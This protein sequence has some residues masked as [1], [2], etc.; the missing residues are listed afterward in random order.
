MSYTLLHCPHPSESLYC[1]AQKHMGNA[2]K[3]ITVSVDD[4]TY[5]LARIKAAE[6]GTSVSAMVRDYLKHLTQLPTPRR[7]LGEIVESIRARGG[8]LHSSDNL[9]REELHGRNALR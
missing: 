3:N 1:A 5:R 2:M 6:N 8:G 7:T 4:E 9:T